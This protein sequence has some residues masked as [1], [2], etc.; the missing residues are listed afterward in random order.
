MSHQSERAVLEI[1][2]AALGRTDGPLLLAVSGGM[3]S[4]ALLHALACVA[5]ERIAAVATFDHG[6]GDAA[7]RAAAHVMREHSD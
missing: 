4:M 1:V 2:R 6:T 3:D 5:R 7:T